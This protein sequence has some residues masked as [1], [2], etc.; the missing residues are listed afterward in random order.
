MSLHGVL[1]AGILI[2]ARLTFMATVLF[3]P[4]FWNLRHPSGLIREQIRLAGGFNLWQSIASSRSLTVSGAW[5]SFNSFPIIRVTSGITHPV[6]CLSSWIISLALPVLAQAKCWEPKSISY[7]TVNLTKSNERGEKTAFNRSVSPSGF[8]ANCPQRD[9][10][11]YM[12]KPVGLRSLADMTCNKICW[13]SDN[14]AT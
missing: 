10:P 8:R 13:M 5:H 7:S 11:V 14:S 2:R 4:C 9:F 1:K 12:E 6:E 3:Q